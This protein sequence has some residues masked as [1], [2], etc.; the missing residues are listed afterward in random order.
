MNIRVTVKQLGKKRNKITD[1]DFKLDNTPNTVYELIKEA[2]HTCVLEYNRR[3]QKGEDEVCL[4][5][6]EIEDMSEIGKIAFGINYGGKTACENEA[7]ESAVTAYEDGLVRIF[8]GEDELTE[9]NQPIDIKE[10]DGFT[11]IRLTMLAGS[12]F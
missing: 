12:M 7:V 4:T 10:N 6:Q 11:F 8:K 5:K 3:V 1:M 2:V 9:L